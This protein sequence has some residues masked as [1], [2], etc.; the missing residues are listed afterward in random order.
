MNRPATV[1]DSAPA[2]GVDPVNLS[3]PGVRAG[4][5][6]WATAVRRLSRNRSAVVSVIVLCIIMVL[7]ALAPL[8]ADLAGSDPFRSNLGGSITLFKGLHEMV[9]LLTERDS[10]AP[11]SL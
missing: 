3:A 8:Y 7:S 11:L 4:R 10:L 6:P 9:V 1:S 5:G 2:A